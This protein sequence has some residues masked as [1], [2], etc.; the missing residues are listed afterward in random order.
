MGEISHGFIVENQTLTAPICVPPRFLSAIFSVAFFWFVQNA[1]GDFRLYV[2]EVV[3]AEGGRA[4]SCVILVGT[5][6]FS[7]SP[8]P[9]WNVRGDEIARSVILRSPDQAA[10]IQFK[11]Q[12]DSIR[13]NTPDLRRF[14]SGA[15]PGSRIRGETKCFSGNSEELTLDLVRPIK[16]SFSV[17]IRTTL[18]RLSPEIVEVSLTSSPQRFTPHLPVFNNV[19]TSLREEIPKTHR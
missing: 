13:T 14:V 4:T 16:D 7:F 5:N 11:F 18:V 12:P 9:N 1:S 10:T 19:I 8:P 6:R 2:Q 3:D 17:Y 15:Y